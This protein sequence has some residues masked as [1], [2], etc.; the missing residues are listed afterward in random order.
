MNEQTEQ[1]NQEMWDSIKWCDIYIII[2]PEGEE[3]TRQN[4]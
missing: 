1:N 2:I 3:R 4:I